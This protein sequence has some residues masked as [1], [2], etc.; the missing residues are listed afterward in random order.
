MA[1]ITANILVYEQHTGMS[2][3]A[4]SPFG[5]KEI[6]VETPA[7]ADSGDTFTITLADYGMSAFKLIRGWTFTTANSVCVVEAPTTAVAAGVL[8][9]TL[10]GAANN[11]QRTFLIGGV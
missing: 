4:N 7:T 5:Y 6:M 10:G 1:D 3:E 9:V 8:T 2:Q 11:Q